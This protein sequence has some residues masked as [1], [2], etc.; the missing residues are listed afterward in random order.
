MSLRNHISVES[1]VFDPR[2]IPHDTVE[3]NQK[4]M[5]IMRGAPKWYEVSA[6]SA[7]G[8]NVTRCFSRFL[9]FCFLFPLFFSFLDGRSI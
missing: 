8:G 6:I 2:A 5:D 9:G 1:S 3:F 4:L 7:K